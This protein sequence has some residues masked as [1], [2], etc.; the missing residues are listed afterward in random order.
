MQGRG[1]RKKLLFPRSL[2]EFPTKIA[3]F[4]LIYFVHKNSFSG[5]KISQEQG[6]CVSHFF[7]SHGQENIFLSVCLSGG[8]CKLGE[9]SCKTNI[10][11]MIL[12]QYGRITAGTN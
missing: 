9:I 5:D 7:S 6:S 2:I 4:F 1:W 3:T 10:S 8:L 12:L 11:V